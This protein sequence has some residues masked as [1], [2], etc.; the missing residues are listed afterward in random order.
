M[1][2]RNMN[3]VPITMVVVELA[4]H[5][6]QQLHEWLAGN[7][8]DQLSSATLRRIMERQNAVMA[9]LISELELESRNRSD[10]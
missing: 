1:N 6:Q 7:V 2:E 5:A 8:L 4:R 3:S 10:D 9:L